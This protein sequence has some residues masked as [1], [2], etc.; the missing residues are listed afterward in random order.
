MDVRERLLQSQRQHGVVLFGTNSATPWPSNLEKYRFD[1]VWILFS[2][3]LFSIKSKCTWNVLSGCALTCPDEPRVGFRNSECF[4][5]DRN[6][7]SRKPRLNFSDIGL[8][9]Q[10]LKFLR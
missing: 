10:P 8:F 9:I 5:Q 6:R 1:F 3:N 2:D 4:L 7:H